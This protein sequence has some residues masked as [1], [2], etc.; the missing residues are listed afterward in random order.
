M[1]SQLKIEALDKHHVVKH[2]DCGDSALNEFIKRYAFKQQ[3]KKVGQTFVAINN[4]NVIAFYTIS[5]GSVRHQDA[6]ETLAKGLPRY[7]IPT[8]TLGR[9]AVHTNEQG[10]GMGAMLLKDALHKIL[11]VAKT[12]G[13]V[14]VVVHAK[15][16][17]AVKFY[18]QYGFIPFHDKPFTL[19]LPLKQLIF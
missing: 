1:A 12:I 13:I 7:P 5:A 8:V 14:A 9:L 15:N 16:A 17:N 3:K 11:S 6:P 18:Q 2:F 4:D 19:F 10:K